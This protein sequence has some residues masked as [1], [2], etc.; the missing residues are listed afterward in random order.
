MTHQA[1][2]HCGWLTKLAVVTIA[3]LATVLCFLQAPLP[4]MAFSTNQNPR[5]IA[6]ATMSKKS[7]AAA[8]DVEGKLE[9]A[10]GEL[11]GDTGHQ[12]KGKAKQIQ[13][14]AMNAAEDIKEGAKSTAKKVSEAAQDMIDDIS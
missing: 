13:A 4:A 2:Q 11:T 14:S 8:K 10:Y 6:I 5:P 12:I 3:S 1:K 9:S 7:D